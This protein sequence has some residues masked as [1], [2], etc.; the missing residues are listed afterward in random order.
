MLAFTR[1]ALVGTSAKC[2]GDALKPPVTA[3]RTL[4]SMGREDEI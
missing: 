1:S 3:A 2:S 4:G